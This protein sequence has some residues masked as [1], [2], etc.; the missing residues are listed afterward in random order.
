MQICDGSHT[1]FELLGPNIDPRGDDNKDSMCLVGEMVSEILG[2]C[3]LS[4]PRS[5][6]TMTGLTRLHMGVSVQ[7][8]Q[9]TEGSVG[10]T[11]GLRVEKGPAHPFVLQQ[12]LLFT[13]NFCF[14]PTRSCKKYQ[15][16]EL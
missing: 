1:P 3:L 6:L 14:T 13:L 8:A 4:S 7:K 16:H 9:S 10:S 11:L 15:A 5:Q 12:K 2:F